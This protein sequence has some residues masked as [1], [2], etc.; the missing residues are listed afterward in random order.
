MEH[1][2]NGTHSSPI[3]ISHR[4]S[5]NFPESFGKW[6]TPAVSTFSPIY[7]GTRRCR[8]VYLGAV[9]LGVSEHAR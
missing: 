2:L 3:N 5:R 4:N 1:V 9:V 6:K 7:P 8:S